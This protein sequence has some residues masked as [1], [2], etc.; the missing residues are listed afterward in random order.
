MWPCISASPGIRYFPWPLTCTAPSGT[1]V[2]FAG[3]NA[4]MRSLVTTTVWF[5]NTRLVSI[6]TTATLVKATSRPGWAVSGR[7]TKGRTSSEPTRI[8]SH[9]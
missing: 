9:I 1:R 3:P 2:E 6:G 7:A 5:D 4:V 8:P